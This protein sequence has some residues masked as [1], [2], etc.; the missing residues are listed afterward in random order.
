MIV[1]WPWHFLVVWGISFPLIVRVNHALFKTLF[2]GL[3]HASKSRFNRKSVGG[4]IGLV[5]FNII[6]AIA[7]ILYA[8]YYGSSGYLVLNLN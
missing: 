1:G 4:F 5:L 3:V 7:F 6:F 2:N 8:V